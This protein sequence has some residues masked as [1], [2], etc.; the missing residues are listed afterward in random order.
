M[1]AREAQELVAPRR[2]GTLAFD[3]GTVS[4]SLIV[5]KGAHTALQPYGVR[6]CAHAVLSLF[7]DMQCY[8]SVKNIMP[9]LAYTFFFHSLG[10]LIL[11]DDG[12]PEIYTE[13]YASASCHTDPWSLSNV[14]NRTSS[15]RL[16]SLNDGD[17]SE[18]HL[19]SRLF[20]ASVTQTELDLVDAD[21][22]DWRV[23]GGGSLVLASAVLDLAPTSVSLSVL[24]FVS[25]PYDVDC[26]TDTLGCRITFLSWPPV[27][28]C[29]VDAVCFWCDLQIIVLLVDSLRRCLPNRCK[30]CHRLHVSVFDHGVR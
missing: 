19:R 3:S 11:H 14:A 29:H 17:R 24:G 10:V 30:K 8:Q 27:R 5:R 13:K 16:V 23:G 2:S 28:R 1:G 25:C 12:V 20:L 22:S 15:R 18:R 4:V 7:C 6:P 9:V 26:V 21:M